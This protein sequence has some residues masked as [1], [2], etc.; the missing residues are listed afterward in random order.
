MRLIEELGGKCIRCGFSHEASLVFHHI[1]GKKTEISVMLGKGFSYKKL[2]KEIENCVLLCAN[3]HSILHW[4][5]N[6][7]ENSEN[8]MNNFIKQETTTN[9][10]NLKMVIIV[11][12][13]L[14]MGFGKTV[15]QVAHGILNVVNLANK[16]TVKKWNV[17]GYTKIVLKATEAEIKKAVNELENVGIPYFKVYDMGKTQINQNS[18]T[19]L[20]IPPIEAEKIDQIT[21]KFKLL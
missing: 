1:R 10:L 20:A 9:L 8:S 5:N 13:D 14:K 16:E 12:N 6:Q 15:A 18:F 4:E 3:C 19:V 7:R 2:R 11:N 21:R 17:G